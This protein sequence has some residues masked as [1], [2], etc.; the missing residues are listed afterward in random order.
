MLIDFSFIEYFAHRIIRVYTSKYISLSLPGVEVIDGSHNNQ[1]N[2]CV[3][4][5]YLNHKKII[6][7]ICNVRNY[8]NK[9]I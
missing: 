3:F 7:T 2:A 4:T 6:I 5:V 8:G 1:E 9:T